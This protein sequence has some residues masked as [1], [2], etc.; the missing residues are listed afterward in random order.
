MTHLK[1]RQDNPNVKELFDAIEQIKKEFESIE[2]PTLEIETTSPKGERPSEEK[3]HRGSHV[4]ET[5][6]IAQTKKEVSPKSA[7]VP[8]DNY[9]DPKAELVKLES[10]SI[11]RPTLAIKTPS[12]KGGRTSEEKSQSGSHVPE[13]VEI[14][15]TK[16]EISPKSA[17]VPRDNYLDPEAE[18]VKLKSESVKRTTLDIETPSPK[19]GRPT[20]GKSHRGSHVTETDEIAQTKK[21]VSPLS[22]SIPRDN[23]LNPEAAVKLESESEFGNMSKVLDT[24]QQDLKPSHSISNE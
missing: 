15:Q 1:C 24:L 17:F 8:R 16:K 23:Y 4:I 7:S 21:E 11:E 14:G 6:E 10:E 3:L 19:G 20:E 5:V 2:R 13:S 9:L 12:P 22:A 18:P